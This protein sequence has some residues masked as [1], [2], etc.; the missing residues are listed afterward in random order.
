MDGQVD[1]FDLIDE[2]PPVPPFTVWTC[3]WAGD[4]RCGWCGGKGFQGGGACR[5]PRNDDEPFFY[6]YC[7]KCYEAYGDPHV[8]RLDSV[9]NI[10]RTQK[11]RPG[12]AP[13]LSGK[14]KEG[15]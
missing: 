10:D 14:P 8:R 7:R 12:D 9:I 4:L 1:L 3:V 2:R 11:P 13:N 6:Q 5:N 15:T